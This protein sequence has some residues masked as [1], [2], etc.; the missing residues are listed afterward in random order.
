MMAKVI[1]EAVRNV[2]ITT[3]TDIL[4]DIQHLTTRLYTL[5]VFFRNITAIKK[6][7]SPG[8]R[9]FM[10]TEIKR[11]RQASSDNRNLLRLHIINEEGINECREKHYQRDTPEYDRTID[12]PQRTHLP[13][14]C[15]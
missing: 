11:F 10:Y 8:N 12:I 7:V 14:D 4:I 13:L 5:T 3:E 6:A 1:T 2:K 15:E 9:L